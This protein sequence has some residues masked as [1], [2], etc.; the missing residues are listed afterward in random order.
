MPPAPSRQQQETYAISQYFTHHCIWHGSKALYVCRMDFIKFPMSRESQNEQTWGFGRIAG[1]PRVQG[2]ID[3][4]H[5]ALQ[6][7]F[8]NAE[9]FRNKKGYH[10]LN[11]QLVCNHTQHILTVNARYPGGAHDAFILHKS[12]VSR[13]FQQQREGHSWLVGDKGYGRAT[14]L[15]TFLRSPIEAEQRYKESHAAT[16]NIIVQT[17]R[18]L[19][20][21]FQYLDPSGGSLKYSPQQISEF[22]V[23]CCMLHNLAIMRGQALPVGTAGP[24][25]EEDDDDEEPGEGPIAQPP[26]PRGRQRGDASRARG[27]RRQLIMDQ[28]A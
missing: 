24:L 13:I 23:V 12:S 21:R 17:I 26:H 1:F 5:M 14:W 9:L 3:C 19:K 10:S 11:V 15:M 27:A 8:N 2:A 16:R 7:P 25:Q 18:V 6:V 28:I 20:Q 4:T 22:I